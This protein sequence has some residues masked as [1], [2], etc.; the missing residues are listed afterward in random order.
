MVSSKA[1]LGES[2][3]RFLFVL[4][5]G[6]LGGC[7]APDGEDYDE[8][9]DEEGE[10]EED[11]EDE[12]RLS[13]I[14]ANFRVTFSAASLQGNETS[15]VGFPSS[16]GI[17]LFVSYNS[18]PLT[19]RPDGTT[20]RCGWAVSLNGAGFA[21]YDDGT[22]PLPG[23]GAGSD[24]SPYK[25][26]LG[27]TWSTDASYSQTSP[28]VAMVAIAR[29]TNPE[30]LQCG[31]DGW[32]DVAMWTSTNG[33][34]SFS[35]VALL[36][37]QMSSGGCVDGP[38]VEW[39]ATNHT[40]WVWWWNFNKI[41]LRP[42]AISAGGAITPGATIDLTGK[43]KHNSPTHVTMAIKPGAVGGPPTIWLAYADDGHGQWTHCE[44]PANWQTISVNWWLSNS[45]DGGVTWTHL[46]VDSDPAWPRC[47]SATE[48]GANR[49]MISSIYDPSSDR[50]MV[51]YSRHI[52]DSAGNFVGTR[53]KIKQTPRAD[54]NPNFFNSWTSM[55]NAAVCP[56][57]PPTGMTCFIEGAPPVG[58]TF[59]HE[60]GPALGVKSSGT[61]RV[62][63][64]WHDTRDSQLN[65]A[66]PHPA[67]G[68]NV[69]VKPLLSDV[70]GV[71]LRSGSPYDLEPR[72]GGNLTPVG[73]SIPWQEKGQN[74]NLWWGDY[75]DGVVNWGTKFYG[76]W[77]DNRD[78][79]TTTKLYGAEFNE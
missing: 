37:N 62:A 11:E 39:D 58:E 45:T 4:L 22:T 18:N 19:P 41:Y 2:L 35:S 3:V 64:V 54:G 31:H 10:D 43:L 29:N 72:T 47:I 14:G 66:F 63:V 44:L 53:I 16:P 6:S 24:G 57:P 30:P 28:N 12:Y 77:G 7:E 33:G 26:C 55:C 61:R 20:T 9:E 36:S 27:D 42:V 59:C 56:Q 34:S 17:K 71:S 25:F 69:T 78:G 49:T 21:S 73:A 67:V 60:F 74:G 52:D 68:D 48:R 5:L 51:A 70:R 23:Y 46:K 1:R 15:A 32:R 13:A 50:V 38:K 40:A 65:P 79:T 76:I 8:D 75:E